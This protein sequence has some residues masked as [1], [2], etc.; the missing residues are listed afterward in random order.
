MAASTGLERKNV[1]LIYAYPGFRG[2]SNDGKYID[3]VTLDNLPNTDAVIVDCCKKIFA[4]STMLRILR[5]EREQERRCPSCRTP[6]NERIIEQSDFRNESSILELQ[7]QIFDLT[8]K[9]NSS[10]E[11]LQ[12]HLISERTHAKSTAAQQRKNAEIDKEIFRLSQNLTEILHKIK[13]NIITLDVCEKQLFNIIDKLLIIAG[14]LYEENTKQSYKILFNKVLKILKILLTC[15]ENHLKS[16][17][18]KSSEHNKSLTNTVAEQNQQ[19]QQANEQLK[20][21]NISYF[22][23]C[24][25]VADK[26]FNFLWKNDIAYFT[27]MSTA[28]LATSYGYKTL[29]SYSL[30]DRVGILGGIN[31]FGF[32][33]NDFILNK[34]NSKPL[35]KL[36]LSGL[37]SVTPFIYTFT[38]LFFKNINRN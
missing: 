13:T 12:R 6:L 26:V 37:I 34:N 24:F 4:K 9:L 5:S 27:L 19:L 20:K 21:H 30:I 1:Y 8:F 32:S 18:E 28:L 36:V 7:Q 11:E 3:P 38:D 15:K 10:K 14:N 35:K 29:D 2:E 25:N 33:I 31:L 22:S 17:L 23:K 16:T